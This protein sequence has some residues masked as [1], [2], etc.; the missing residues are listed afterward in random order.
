MI[1]IASIQD[2]D[3]LTIL[4]DKYMVFY[5]KPT[6]F[7]RHKQFLKDRIEN[8]D[9]TVFIAINDEDNV[10]GFALVYST[11]SSVRLSKILILNDL[12]V[13]SD[14]RNSGIGE[15]LIEKVVE[16]AKE[17]G[18]DMVRLRTA[19]TN[20]TAQGLYQKMGFVT[21]DVYLTCDLVV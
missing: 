3:Q 2:L 8:K 18:A 9:C 11:F 13:N 5:N 6:D 10:V 15:R 1:K 21:D 7:E 20:T 16:L 14:L 4:F 17:T 19:K 12:Y